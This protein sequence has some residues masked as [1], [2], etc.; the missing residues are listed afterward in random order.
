MKSYQVVKTLECSLPLLEQER[1]K[2]VALIAELLKSYPNTD[3]KVLLTQLRFIRQVK[4]DE[5]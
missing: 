4:G 2:A 3:M 1:A 5:S